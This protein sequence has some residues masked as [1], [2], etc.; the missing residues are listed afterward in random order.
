MT[1]KLQNRFLARRVSDDSPIKPVD[2][3]GRLPAS[4]QQEGLWFL[5]RLDK[6]AGRAYHVGG[7]VRLKGPL[8]VAALEAALAAIVARHESLRTTFRTAS[9]GQVVVVIALAEKGFKVPLE[10]GSQRS[11]RDLRARAAAI[12][13]EPFDLAAHP[14]FR[15]RLLHLGDQEHVLVIAGHHTVLDGWSV[16][17][18]LK[19]MSALYREAVSGTPAALPDLA[20]Q[21]ADYAA[22][23][24]TVLSGDRLAEE[25]AWWRERLS[26]IPE[27]ITLPFD[28]P[29]PKVM[30]YRGG[31]VPT[32]ISP[33]VTAGLTALAR[34]EGATLFMVLEA[35][36]TALLSRLGAGEDVVIGTAVAGRPR[37]ELED[38]AGFFVNTVA[39][40]NTVDGLASFREHLGAA[41][42]MVLDAFAHQQVPFEAVVEALSPTR[43]MGHAPLVQVMLVLQNT[44]DA[45]AVLTLPGLDVAPFDQSAQ[46]AHFELSLNLTETDGGLTGTLSYASQVFERETV[47][48]FAAMFTRL[49]GA[50]VAAP[51]TVLAD[52]PLM[53]DAERHQVVALFNDTAV[54]YQRETTVIDLFCAQAAERPDAVAVVDGERTLS[55]GALDAASNQLARHLIGQGVGPEVVVG[56]CLERSAELIIALMAI[57]KAGGAYLPL[58]PDYPE[59]RL[60]FM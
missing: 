56:V 29:R 13:A 24:R 38:L 55:Y 19:E 39:L 7:A 25:T 14:L 27:A 33:D 2:R 18:L 6:A 9:D 60:H 45:G 32:Q 47:E 8:Q 42:A 16:G 48:R 44:P 28:R 54:D 51:D 50:A 46:T 58:D 52:L 5:D 35:A 49:L 31:S 30:D 17:L 15:A 20:I 59:A 34:S 22:W 10:D 57:W 4:Y 21:Y 11:A 53:D 12:L 41:K 23:Q 43:A 1:N 36:F 37:R 3:S 40:R 26:G